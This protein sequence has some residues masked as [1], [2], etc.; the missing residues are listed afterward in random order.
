MRRKARRTAARKRAKTNQDKHAREARRV[1]FT[2]QRKRK[3]GG[4]GKRRKE[5]KG[6]EG[7]KEGK[8]RQE[9]TEKEGRKRKAGGKG[10][11]RKESKGKEGR[12]GRE[13]N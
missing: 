4:K 9:G 2:W 10:K 8:G 11:G 1:S 12:R 13:R 5:G 6:K 3:A 7:R